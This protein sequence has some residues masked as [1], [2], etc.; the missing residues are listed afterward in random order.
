MVAQN[1]GL[2]NPEIS[3]VIGEQWRDSP[4]EVKKHWKSL[5]DVCSS[6]QGVLDIDE[7]TPCRR[8]NFVTRNSTQ[9]IA[10]SHDALAVATVPQV[11][12]LDLPQVK[13]P[14]VA[15]AADEPSRLQ[16]ACPQ[17]QQIR[18]KDRQLR[19]VHLLDHKLPVGPVTS[20]P[21]VVLGLMG[22][23]AFTIIPISDNME[24]SM[25]SHL[26]ASSVRLQEGLS[27]QSIQSAAV[28]A[29]QLITRLCVSHMDLQRLS[30]TVEIPSHHL[31]SSL[32]L[33]A[34]PETE[35]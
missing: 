30:R 4:A 20:A 27:H 16:P 32:I 25:A 11:L 31:T 12:K 18:K 1:P 2:A 9:T 22:L 15:N 6:L 28:S 21:S 5:A 10:T 33:Q 26:H 29:H 35:I 19:H 13:H 17:C 34:S 14:V 24:C 3:K 23:L 8:R 7:L